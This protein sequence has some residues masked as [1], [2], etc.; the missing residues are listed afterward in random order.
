ML[1]LTLLAYGQWLAAPGFA[2]EF[3][4]AKNLYGQGKFDEAIQLLAVKLRKKPDHEDSIRLLPVVLNACYNHHLE[5]ARESEKRGEWD[6]ALEHYDALVAITRELATLPPL[7]DKKTR[8][9]V[10]L[11]KVDVTEARDKALREKE[12]ALRNAAEAHYQKGLAAM[13]ESGASARAVQEFDAALRFIADYKDA[14][15]M[16]VEALYRDAL[17]FMER[18]NF[19]SAYR[20]LDKCRARAPGYKETDKLLAEIRHKARVRIALMPFTN[21]SGNTQ[22]GDPGQLVAQE[23]HRQLASQ[24]PGVVEFYTEDY[25]RQQVAKQLVA[26]GK[27]DPAMAFTFKPEL[28]EAAA[29]EVGKAIGIDYFVFGKVARIYIPPPKG[30]VQVAQGEARFRPTFEQVFRGEKT[31]AVEWQL[32]REEAS[33]E[34]DASWEVRAVDTGQQLFYETPHQ[35]ALDRTEWIIYRQKAQRQQSLKPKDQLK[36]RLKGGPRWADYAGEEI[37]IPKEILAR[38]TGNRRPKPANQL[39]RDAVAKIAEDVAGKLRSRLEL[40]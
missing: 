30:Y 16:A 3:K 21:Q 24:S 4:D 14:R 2:D 17:Y 29:V 31:A 35:A 9:P 36:D 32:W 6:A 20:K 8:A 39:V 18:N 11:P 33:A 5:L 26:A 1:C 40:D 23:V 19:R 37:L 38:H 25:V 12:N 27:L 10:E 15:Q 22:F 34:V 7:V 13:Q 28:T